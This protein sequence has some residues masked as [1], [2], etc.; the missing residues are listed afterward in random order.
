MLASPT[1]RTPVAPF[2]PVPPPRSWRRSASS[3]VW[4]VYFFA[5]ARVAAAAFGVSCEYH[6]TT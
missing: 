2:I 3:I 6:L 5:G 4:S 1:G